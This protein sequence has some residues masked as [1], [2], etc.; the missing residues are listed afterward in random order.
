MTIPTNIPETPMAHSNYESIQESKENSTSPK[1][2]EVYH[3]VLNKVM[4]IKYEDETES[5]SKWMTYRGH[6][7]FTDLCVDFHHELDH[8]HE[9]SDYRV[10]GIKCALKFG[11]TNKLSLLIT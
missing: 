4:D 9:S 11:T 8:I 1:S 2:M 5:F 6:E 10:E 7:N 3:H